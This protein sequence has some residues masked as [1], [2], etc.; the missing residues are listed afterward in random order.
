LP[1]S[2]SLLAAATTNT[3]TDTEAA[4]A[5]TA[6]EEGGTATTTAAGGGEFAGTTV[7]ILSSIRDVEAE[8]LSETWAS[9]EAETD[10]TSSTRATTSKTT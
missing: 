8:R 4:S 3:T 2:C 9:F 6:A 1:A 5:T 10:T 7:T